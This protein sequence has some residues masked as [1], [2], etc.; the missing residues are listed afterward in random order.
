MDCA[1]SLAIVNK[2]F[3]RFGAQAYNDLSDSEHERIELG[4]VECS[5]A[6]VAVKREMAFVVLSFTR[7]SQQRVGI[8]KSARAAAAVLR[9]RYSLLA[10]TLSFVQYLVFFQS[11]RSRG[12][13]RSK[14]LGSCS[15]CREE[16]NESQEGL[17]GIYQALIS[18]QVHYLRLLLPGICH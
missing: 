4:Y 1:A 9:R 6:V 16:P 11:P 3:T 10:I 5:H 13:R 2:R 17:Q 15:R 12:C 8:Q 14:C 18:F 7:F